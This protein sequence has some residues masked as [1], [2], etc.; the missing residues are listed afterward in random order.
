MKRIL[1]TLLFVMLG[2]AAFSAVPTAQSYSQVPT[3]WEYNSSLFSGTG[4]Y[5]PILADP[6][7]GYLGVILEGTSS[8]GGTI[9]YA[10]PAAP[11]SVTTSS[12]LILAAGVYSKFLALCTTPPTVVNVW[13]NLA[14]TQAILGAGIYIPASGGCVVIPPPTAAIYGISSSGTATVTVQGG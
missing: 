4:G 1:T 10:P 13:L 12:T 6:T 9:S 14:G 11:V 7:T 3:A 5:Q 2:S 8:S